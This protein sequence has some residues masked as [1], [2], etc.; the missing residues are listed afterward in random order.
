MEASSATA[1]EVV[2]NCMMS[3]GYCYSEISLNLEQVFGFE[4]LSP[5]ELGVEEIDDGGRAIVL[6]VVDEQVSKSND[7]QW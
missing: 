1:A 6:Y 2:K 7:R 5:R 3:R 4:R